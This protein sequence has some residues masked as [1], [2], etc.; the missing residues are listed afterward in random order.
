[1]KMTR[2]SAVALLMIFLGSTT[3]AVWADPGKNQGRGN[4]SHKMA[5][6]AGHSGK[7]SQKRAADAFSVDIPHIRTVIRNNRD[8][9]GHPSSLPPGIQK[10]L[11]R[12]KPLPPGIAK[13]LDS[14]LLERLPHHD[15]YDWRQAGRDL[16]LISVATG[17]IQE[18]VSGAFD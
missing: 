6:S 3:A 5:T 8:Y 2:F 14:R 17:I 10:N 4:G 7:H 1:M 13:R 12:G 9:W 15:G 18:V 11:A 16:I